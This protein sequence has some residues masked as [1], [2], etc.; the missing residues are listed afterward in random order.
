MIEAML[1]L[2]K[3]EIENTFLNISKKERES[4]ILKRDR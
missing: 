1:G 3:R 2:A 4:I